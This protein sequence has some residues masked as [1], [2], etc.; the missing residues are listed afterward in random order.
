[1]AWSTQKTNWVKTDY[2]NIEDYARWKGNLEH[3]KTLV[4]QVY[5]PITIVQ[6]APEK[7]YESIL[8]ADEFNLIEENLE[9]LKDWIVPLNI[10]AKKL[11]RP[12]GPTPDY[13][14]LN[15]IES[16]MLRMYEN[17]MGQITGRR[18]LSFV[19]NGGIF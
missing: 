14:E 15:R 6:M 18:R 7:T 5:P 12:N 19:L 13:K 16:A 3:L 4:D 17:L 8:Y 9:I 1:M 10:G 11:Y 2:I